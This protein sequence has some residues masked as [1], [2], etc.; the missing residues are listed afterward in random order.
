MPINRPSRALVC[1]FCNSKIFVRRFVEHGL[2]FDHCDLEEAKDLL[3]KAMFPHKDKRGYYGPARVIEG[4]AGAKDFS[5]MTKDQ[6]VAELESRANN[7]FD[8]EVL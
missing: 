4:K 1:P 7:V 5:K 2:K 6:L 8:T 3:S